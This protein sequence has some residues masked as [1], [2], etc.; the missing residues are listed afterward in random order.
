MEVEETAVC[1]Y[2]AHEELV[3]EVPATQT[4]RPSWPIGG[5]QHLVLVSDLRRRQ[6]VDHI[7]NFV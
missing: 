6:R 5:P 1:F 4:S 7:G 3:F 2:P